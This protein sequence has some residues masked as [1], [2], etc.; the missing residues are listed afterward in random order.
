MSEIVPGRQQKT[1]HKIPLPLVAV[2]LGFY[3]WNQGFAFGQWLHV[4]LDR[5]GGAH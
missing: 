3:L 4:A 1:M 2:A 5:L